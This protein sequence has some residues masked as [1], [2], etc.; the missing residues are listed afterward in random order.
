MSQT[1][2]SED[3]RAQILKW[4]Q[5][6]I[7]L[8]DRGLEFYKECLANTQHP[9][10]MELFDFLIKVETGHKK[11]L[12]SVLDGYSKGDEK[13]MHDA[14]HAFMR[15][16]IEPPLF[17]KGSKEKM[18]S[19]L[20]ALHEM[21]NKALDFEKEGAEF[22]RKMEDEELDLDLKKLFRKLAQDEVEHFQEIRQLG[23]FVFGM[24]MTDEEP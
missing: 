6:A 11:A 9:R 19:P 14:L 20:T 16:D 18:T 22:Y 12:Q 17:D 13:V 5:F 10:A 2:I 7:D 1:K 21:F 24:H 3:R 15:M 4:L 23:S 8:E